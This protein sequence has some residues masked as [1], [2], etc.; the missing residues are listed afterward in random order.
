MSLSISVSAP[1]M[2]RFTCLSCSREICRT[3]RDSLSKICPSGTMRTSRMPFCI[4]E[5]WRSNVRWRR[6]SSMPSSRRLGATAHALADA[7]EAAPEDRELADDGHER[8][9]LAD[10][11]PHGLAHRA[12]RELAPAAATVAA[13]AR[14]GRHRRRP[15][16]GGGVRT[17]STSSSAHGDRERLAAPGSARRR[18][19]RLDGRPAPGRRRRAARGARCRGGARSRFGDLFDR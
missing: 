17:A 3:M 15:P 10:V 9:E 7:Q 1:V 5:R 2:T 12:E 8:V 14:C 11:D 19:A 18:A 16:G 13:A 6:C 4:C